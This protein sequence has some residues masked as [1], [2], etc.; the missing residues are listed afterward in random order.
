MSTNESTKEEMMESEPD[1]Y[2]ATALKNG[3]I[4]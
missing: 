3:G 2:E 4:T 1:K